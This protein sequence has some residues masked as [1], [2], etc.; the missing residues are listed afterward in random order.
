MTPLTVIQDN[1]MTDREHMQVCATTDSF[2]CLTL[3]IQLATV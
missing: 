2:A 3:N 1:Y